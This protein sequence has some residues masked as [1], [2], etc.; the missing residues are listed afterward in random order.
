MLW[1]IKELLEV[2]QWISFFNSVG[3]PIKRYVGMC[4]VRILVD[5]GTGLGWRL[6]GVSRSHE[7]G[8][9]ARA[10]AG[11]WNAD[12][13]ALWQPWKELMAVDPEKCLLAE[14]DSLRGALVLLR[15][16]ATT[17]VR[18]INKG[19]G[20]SAKLTA[21]MRRIW[22]LCVRYGI[23]LHAEH[24]SGDRM[25][26]C[27][28]DSLSRLSEFSVSPKVFRLISNKSGFGV[29][30]GFGGYTLDLYASQK[31]AKCR[32]Y[33][34]LGGGGTSVGDAKTFTQLQLRQAKAMLLV[35]GICSTDLRISTHSK[36]V[37]LS[38]WSTTCECTCAMQRMIRR[39]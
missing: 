21:V 12:E 1:L 39:V 4:E 6:D 24:L 36:C 37:T 20:P 26:G 32:K 38:D 15:P 28:V 25:V 3:N 30:S 31:T 22:S 11:D 29:R 33:A 13:A 34:E 18:Y 10:A 14:G 2:L 5:A 8:A 35:S 19:S 16:D 27:G 23:G 9:H 17:T 7:F